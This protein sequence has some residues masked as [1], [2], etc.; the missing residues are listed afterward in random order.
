MGCGPSGLFATHALVQAGWDVKIFSKKRRSEM[1]G[2]Q[3]LHEPIPGLKESKAQV[4]YILQGGTTTEYKQKVYGEDAGDFAVSPELIT[5]DPS[6]A[7][8]IRAAY[9]DAWDRYQ[10]LIVHKPMIT[11]SH[12]QVFSMLEKSDLIVNSIPRFYVCRNPMHRFKSKRVWAV[13]DAPERGVFVEHKLPDGL[14]VCN[15]SAGI[16]WYRASR[17][18]G[19]STM[20]WAKPPAPKY[21]A[22]RVQKPISTNCDCMQDLGIL[23]VGRYGK[24]QKG[25]LSHTAFSDTY[26]R[27]V[28]ES[29]A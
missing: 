5:P 24:W 20:E 23:H 19:Y 7:W 10:D 26:K 16:P 4:R 17:V 13:G 11:G 8:D 29:I 3:Y 12:I 15:A 9:Y 2:A 1:Y 27:I 18:F 21:K 25:V 22:A 14:V 28:G 6:D